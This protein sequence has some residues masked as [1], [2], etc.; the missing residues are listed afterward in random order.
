MS[1]KDVEE[2]GSEDYIRVGYCDGCH[3]GFHFGEDEYDLPNGGNTYTDIQ[4]LNYNWLGDE[5]TNG[6]TCDNPNFYVDKRSIHGSEYL[7]KWLISGNTY[8]LPQNTSI[9]LS[10][11]IDNL[12]DDIDIFLYIGDIGYDM[13]NQSSLIVDSSM[14]YT[15]FDFETY[16]ELVNIKILAGGCA[17]VGTA[18][19]YIDEDDDGMGCGSPQQFCPGFQ[20]DGWVD[21]NNDEGECEC[22]TNNTDGCGICD[23]GNINDLGCGC[24]EPGPSG[25]DNTCDSILEFDDCGICDGDNVNDLGCGC[26]E[27]APSGCD[28][29]CGSN[30]EIDDCGICGG[31][32]INMDDCGECN[33]SNQSCIDQIFGDGPQNFSAFINDESIELTWDHP[34][35]PSG[36]GIIGFNIYIQSDLMEFITSTTEESFILNDNDEGIFCLSAYDQFD[37]ESD[38]TCT[39]ASGMLNMQF[40]LLHEANLISFMGIPTDSSIINIFNP[41]G[42]NITGVIGQGTASN[43]LGNNFWVGSLTILEPTSGYWVKLNDPPVE[44]FLVEAYPTNPNINYDL[45][46]GHNLIS[47]VGIDDL[48]I[49]DAIPDEYENNFLGIIG[50]GMASVQFSP[51]N[52]GGSLVRLNNLDGYWVQ[53]ETAMNFHWNVNEELV[54][55]ST[56][57]TIIKTPIPDEFMY[58]QSTQQAFYFVENIHVDNYD[59]SKEDWLIAYYSNMIIG[60]RQWGGQYS[61]IPTMGIDGSD[62]T[63]GYIEEGMIPEFKLF[64]ESTGELLTLYTEGVTP[65]MNNELTLITLHSHA[66]SINSNIP[67][68]TII[69]GAYPNP[70]NP[71]STIKFSLRDDCHIELSI[72][73][74][75]GKKIKK[76]YSG[77]KGSGFH[78]I[79]WDAKDMPSGMY[80][81]TLN[82]PEGIHSQKL[83]LLK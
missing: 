67:I 65:W 10:W 76:L 40:E 47:Y 52:W 39:E 19:Y 48:P 71:I 25:C 38:Y 66:E 11:S 18:M 56:P 28:N 59:V 36:S 72:H 62:E 1:A 55:E 22:P 45:M 54:R 32:N 83:L 31:G 37:N 2:D 68:S 6:N 16:T 77:F 74:I 53:I 8:N 3:D 60:A 35:Y 29:T 23:G 7:S 20:P 17:S 78:Q 50:Q 46:E 79:T 13:K 42:D 41:L 30:L 63:L 70:F 81:F 64:K 44:S 80:L 27:P 58:S 21:N 75:N 57:Q 73:N 43:N 26:F 69:E 12:I 5:D 34:N 4:I 82:I 15:E 51:G 9:L 49:S 14:L 61:D 24:F 33:G